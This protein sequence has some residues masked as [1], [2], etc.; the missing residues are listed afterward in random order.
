[1]RALLLAVGC[2]VLCVPALRAADDFT[3]EKAKALIPEAA[4]MSKSAL[5]RIDRHLRER[6]IEAGRFPGTQLMVYR[7]GQLVHNSSLGLA[8]IERKIAV[9]RRETGIPVGAG[10]LAKV[11]DVAR[12]SNA[13]W[14]LDG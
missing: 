12:H 13:E 6:Y 14:I 1:M 3:A 7:R 2:C 11:K 5:E 9:Q 10:L 8:D 4:G